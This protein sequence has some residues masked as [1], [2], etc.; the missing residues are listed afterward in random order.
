VLV[1][2]EAGVLHYLDPWFDANGQPLWMPI[3][4]FA[5]AWTGMF[6]PVALP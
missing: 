3:D 5:S 4:V 6:I 2:V 1:G